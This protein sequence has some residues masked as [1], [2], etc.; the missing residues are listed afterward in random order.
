MIVK[1]V[2][3]YTRTTKQA[4]QVVFIYSCIHI[5][6]CVTIIIKE[7][8]HLEEGLKGRKGERKMMALKFKNGD[9]LIVKREVLTV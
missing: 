4:Q 6:M 5:D 3:S 7:S 8:I 1:N 9:Y 2:L